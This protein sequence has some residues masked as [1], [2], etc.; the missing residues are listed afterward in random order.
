MLLQLGIGA[1]VLIGLW[2]LWILVLLNLS[3]RIIC[4]WLAVII[5][6]LI[7]LIIELSRISSSITLRPIV[8]THDLEILKESNRVHGHVTAIPAIFSYDTEINRFHHLILLLNLSGLINIARFNDRRSKASL[9]I[10]KSKITSRVSSHIHH[11]IL[12]APWYLLISQFF[13]K[14]PQKLY[15]NFVFEAL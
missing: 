2:L 8:V 13:L 1:G 9:L 10:P 12:V 7:R 4:I 15:L 11:I 14:K 3:A 6:I 5:I